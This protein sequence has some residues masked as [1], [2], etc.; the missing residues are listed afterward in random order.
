MRIR[1]EE[2]DETIETTLEDLLRALQAV[3]EN[4]DEIEAVLACMLDEQRLR[5]FFRPALAA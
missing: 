2:R 5:V 4:D 3:T 1:I